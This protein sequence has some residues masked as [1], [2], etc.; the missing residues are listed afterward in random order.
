MEEQEA[1]KEGFWPTTL[2]LTPIIFG[3]VLVFFMLKPFLA[4]RA[5]EVEPYLLQRSE[6]AF[7]FAFLAEIARI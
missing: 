1:L 7:L 6:E 5:E 4:K 3:A 2:Y